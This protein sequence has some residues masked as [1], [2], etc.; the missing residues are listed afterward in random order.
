M[1]TASYSCTAGE[2]PAAGSGNENENEI[3]SEGVTSGEKTGKPYLIGSTFLSAERYCIAGN[4]PDSAEITVEGGLE[5]VET[6]AEGGLFVVEVFLEKQKSKN[7]ELRLYARAAGKNISDPLTLTVYADEKRENKPVYVGKNNRLHYEYT[8]DDFLGI[9][10]FEEKEL[11]RLRS[12]AEKLQKKLTEAGLKTELIIFIAPNPATIYPETM[13]DFLQA[14]KAGGNSRAL[15]MAE[16]FESSSVKLIFPYERLL[17]KK[18]DNDLYFFSDTHWNELGAYYGYCELFEYIGKKFPDALPIPEYGIN[19]SETIMYGG[20][21]VSNMLFFD[22]ASY[23]TPSLSVSVR[24]PKAVRIN[25]VG[26]PG[27]GSEIWVMDDGKDRPTV[28][29]CRDS[30]SVAMIH[31]ISETAGKTIINPMWDFSIDMEYI[32][33]SDPDFLILEKVERETRSFAGILR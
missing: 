17:Q 20:D 4:A 18:A 9:N 27:M 22:A 31:P 6:K 23:A 8:L 5:T 16:A 13:S 15:Q 21:I 14:K 7:V 11:V 32:K 2:A 24:D 12:G 1:L 29:I 10:L 28:M 3:L 26:D 19:I 33:E 25:L 30:F